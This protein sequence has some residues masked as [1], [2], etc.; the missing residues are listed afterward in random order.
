MHG[1]ESFLRS[2]MN[3]TVIRQSA[4]KVQKLEPAF[5]LTLLT[6]STVACDNLHLRASVHHR[7]IAPFMYRK[8]YRNSLLHKKTTAVFYK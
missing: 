1:L 6:L 7:H 5:Q 2:Y 3:C 8:F 4:K